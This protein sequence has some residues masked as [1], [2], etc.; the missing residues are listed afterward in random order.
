[1]SMDK[2]GCQKFSGKQ[3]HL[4]AGMTDI[5]IM[6]VAARRGAGMDG[7]AMRTWKQANGRKGELGCGM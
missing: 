7:E 1:M 2:Q 6:T 3:W 4:E 5:W